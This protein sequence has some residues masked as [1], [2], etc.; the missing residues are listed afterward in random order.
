V[1]RWLSS[2]WRRRVHH[3]AAGIGVGERARAVERAKRGDCEANEGARER[4]GGSWQAP[5]CSAEVAPIGETVDAA[6]FQNE[7]YQDACRRPARLRS[8]EYFFMLIA[9]AKATSTKEASAFP[10]STAKNWR[11]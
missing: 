4:R 2:A 9:E 8:R 6:S 5:C 1:K 10:A 7:A 3:R 11:G